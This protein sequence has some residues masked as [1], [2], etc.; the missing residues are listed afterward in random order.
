[1]IEQAMHFSSGINRP[2]FEAA[3][4]YLQVTS[5][6]SHNKCAF[7]N[8]YRGVPFRMTPL[9]DIEEYLQTVRRHYGPVPPA[10]HIAVLLSVPASEQLLSRWQS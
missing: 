4:A 6:C 3:S 8:M 9:E 7:C 10:D 5:G 1:M 2:P